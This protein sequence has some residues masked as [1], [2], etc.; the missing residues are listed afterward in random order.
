MT[1]YDL[2]GIKTVEKEPLRI[3]SATE[4]LQP[5]LYPTVQLQEEHMGNSVPREYKGAVCFRCKG[6]LSPTASWKDR[7]TQIIK[8]VKY[9]VFNKGEYY[10]RAFRRNE[11]QC[12]VCFFENNG[13]DNDEL[14]RSEFQ[15]RE[16]TSSRDACVTIAAMSDNEFL[17]TSCADIIRS[18]T[19]CGTECNEDNQENVETPRPIPPPYNTKE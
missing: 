9:R 10:R 5:C 14:L 13:G 7:D 17:K 11:Y 15:R 1:K 16:H 6:T 4:T 18:P 12:R 8:G 3:P 19:L 2:K